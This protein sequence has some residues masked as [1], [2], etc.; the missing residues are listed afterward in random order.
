M[1]QLSLGLLDVGQLEN[2]LQLVEAFILHGFSL[3]VQRGGHTGVPHRA[4]EVIQKIEEREAVA[5]EFHGRGGGQQLMQGFALRTGPR[6][7]RIGT[8][9]KKFKQGLLQQF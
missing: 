4:L 3:A 8:V 6:D 1:G 9:R 5:V 7:G 2:L